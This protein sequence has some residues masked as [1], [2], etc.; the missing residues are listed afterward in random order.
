MFT[1]SNP[2]RITEASQD[3]KAR[4]STEMN[5]VFCAEYREEEVQFAL[6][7]MHPIKAP[8][9]DGICPIFFQSYGHTVGSSST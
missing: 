4:V 5:N 2:P 1:L 6:S 7:H 3:F 8:R 9:S